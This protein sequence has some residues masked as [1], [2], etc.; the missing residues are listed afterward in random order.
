MDRLI[1]TYIYIFISIFIYNT[2]NV[3]LNLVYKI[4][5]LTNKKIDGKIS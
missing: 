5:K 2:M 4:N 3:Q 1:C